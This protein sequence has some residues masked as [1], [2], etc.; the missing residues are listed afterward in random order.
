[1][2]AR[3]DLAAALYASVDRLD[4][5]L[6]ET[7]HLHYY[8]DLTLQETA[9]AMGVAGIGPIDNPADLPAAL[10]RGVDIVKCGE[11]VIIDVVMQPR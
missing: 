1:M 9:D 4:A 10:K 3:T 6:R 8:Q 2:V 11:P 5:D 7:I